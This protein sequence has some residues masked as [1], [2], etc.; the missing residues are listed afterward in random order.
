MLNNIYIL[1]NLNKNKKMQKK[2]ISII[3][4]GLFLTLLF[5]VN[6]SPSVKIKFDQM[7]SIFYVDDDFNETIPGW[8]ITNFNKIQNAVNNAS[9]NDTIYVF[10]GTYYENIIINKSIILT[11]E[12]KD[13][14]IISGVNFETGII[15][16]CNTTNV[17]ISNFNITSLNQNLSVSGITIRRD[18]RNIA[19]KNNIISNNHYGILLYGLKN[20]VSFNNFLI[21]NI[22]IYVYSNENIIHHNIVEKNVE[23]FSILGENNQIYNNSI[24]QNQY[25]FKK[26]GRRSNITMNII[27]NNTYGLWTSYVMYHYDLF[28][29]ITNNN[30]ID[31]DKNLYRFWNNGNFYR[32]WENG[33]NANYW[34]EWIGIK[35][36]K[37]GFLPYRIP[38]TPNHKYG[39]LPVYFLNFDRN[40]ASEPYD[41][42]IGGMN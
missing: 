23:G 7:N 14:T 42:D 5:N 21:N 11:G 9:T 31:N 33:F 29:E 6:S 19:V 12:S 27:I 24:S 28:N 40:P 30:F 15:V 10:N 36:P 38:G 2:I 13:S 34:D 1:Y 26:L 41:I 4:I 22:S 20:D 37:L 8:N 25:G 39:R 35:Y 18:S 3:V 32:F 16:I 17:S